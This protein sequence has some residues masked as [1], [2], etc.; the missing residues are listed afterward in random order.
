MR[1]NAKK[2]LDLY[3]QGKS[4]HQVA[5][6]MGCTPANVHHVVHRYADFHYKVEAIPVEH[7]RWLVDSA[8]KQRVPAAR[9]AAKLLQEIIETYMSE[10][11]Q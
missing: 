11:E 3:Q 1:E 9:L 10:G 2:I 8:K 6:E 7:V 4:M 5:R